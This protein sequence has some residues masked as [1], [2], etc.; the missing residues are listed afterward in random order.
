MTIS[1]ILVEVPSAFVQVIAERFYI[2]PDRGLLWSLLAFRII[3][4]TLIV[5]L[6]SQSLAKR[7]FEKQNQN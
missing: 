2:P 5:F 4:C 7:L 1:I 6:L 3:F